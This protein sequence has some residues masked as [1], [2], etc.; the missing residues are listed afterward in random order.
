M[1]SSEQKLGNRVQRFAVSAFTERLPYK[2]AAVFLALVLW[3]VVSSEEPTER[4]VDVTFIPQLDSAITLVGSRPPIGDLSALVAGS[5]REL[6]NLVTNP[7]TL[8]RI[9]GPDTPDSVRLELT[10]NDVELPIG[11]TARVALVA[12]GAV[13]LYF[14]RRVTKRV[15]VRSLLRV[16]TDSGFILV[17]EPVLAPDSVML[18]GARED[19]DGINE[20]PT[21]RADVTVR[22]DEPIVVPLD[23]AGLGVRVSPASIRL[24]ATIARDTLLPIPA[25]LPWF[26]D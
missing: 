8:R 1:R 9:F 12:P 26:R 4:I 15:P 7:P 17:G 2:A 16:V 20:V 21:Q 14:D 3:L 18:T 10:A 23:T 24:R 6:M 22:D 5:G 19:L 13:T 25:L 11:V